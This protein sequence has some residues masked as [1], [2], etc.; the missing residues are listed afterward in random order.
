MRPAL[1]SSDNHWQRMMTDTDSEL[2]LLTPLL[3]SKKSSIRGFKGTATAILTV[4]FLSTGTSALA[5][6]QFSLST[7]PDILFD[8]SNS[9]SGPIKGVHNG[10][11]YEIIQGY[12]IA[13]GDMVLGRL[14]A[15]GKLEIPTATRALAA[16]SLLDRWPDGIVPYQFA[17]NASD[18]M[19]NNVMQA[20]EH[21]N[22]KTRL[23]LVERTADNAEL[24]PNYVNFEP[25]NGCASWVGRIGGEQAVWL[26]DDCSVGS[27]VHEIGHAIGIFHEHTR[28]DRDNFIT[29]NWNNIYSNKTENFDILIDAEAI[30]SYDY[31]SIMHYGE[32]FFSNNGQ[33]TISVPDN[34]S[35]GQRIALSASDIAA[36]N[37]MYATDLQLNVST[38]EEDADTN[39][40]IDINVSNRGALGA[41]QL[42]LTARIGDDSDWVSVSSNSGW[43]CQKFGAELRCTRDQLI[44]N[45][46]SVFTVIA[47]PKSSSIDDLSIRVESRTLD[48]DLS[49]NVF[50]DEIV[51]EQQA[52]D[53]NTG[54][55][56]PIENNSQNSN[57]NQNN[58]DS[59]EPAVQA[60]NPEPDNTS[61]SQS[62][63]DSGGGSLNRYFLLLLIVG[64]FRKNLRRR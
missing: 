13:Q 45:T 50:N 29:V 1:L 37:Q 26:A 61:N 55:S 10:I 22:S 51:A 52:Q 36:A 32:R 46:T 64:L 5:N 62:S 56:T 24:Y 31:G 7:T 14:F 28:P 53:S 12:A 27:V 17:V 48:T 57:E 18:T 19:R 23:L 3:R 35:I 9:E 33:S 30:G 41:N 20:V 34:V 40:P 60:A 39:T 58:T 63:T 43:L 21:W 44:E 49:N 16:G 38:R 25:S 2:S 6:E 4:A 11:P 47:D 42:T 54:E 15:N 8:D 59:T